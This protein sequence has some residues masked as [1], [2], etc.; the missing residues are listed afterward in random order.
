M[1]EGALDLGVRP[2]Q[3]PRRL[4]LVLHRGRRRVRHRREPAQL[5]RVGGGEGGAGG[6]GRPRPALPRPSLQA[7]R[8]A[9]AHL[10]LGGGGLPPE[11][12][13]PP[14]PEPPAHD[15][16]RGLRARPRGFLGG[17]HGRAVPQG[18][19]RRRPVRHQGRGGEGAL[20][21]LH[22]RPPLHVQAA[23]GAEEGLV[24]RLQHR[25]EVRGGVLQRGERYLP[26]HEAGAYEEDVRALVRGMQPE[27][28]I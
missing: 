4:R 18:G 26:L 22:A 23:G 14:P 28:L 5:P 7:Q 13:R 12:P 2:R 21:P 10:Q 20:P 19:S 15:R 11:P 27:Q 3:L 9:V 25:P 17:R 16:G 8:Q 24:R 1:A 6:G